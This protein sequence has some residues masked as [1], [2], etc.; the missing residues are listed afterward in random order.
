MEPEKNILY[1]DCP[2][3]HSM[4]MVFEHDI[5]CAI[6]RHAIMKDNMTAVNP[7]ASKEEC[8]ALLREN[9]IYG[10]AG[11]FRIIVDNRPGAEKKYSIE[12]CDYI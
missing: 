11:P 3:C 4:I 9:K 6:F 10:C 7:H 5:A 8:D 1:F 2:H 12:V